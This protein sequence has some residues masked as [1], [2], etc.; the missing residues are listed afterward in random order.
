MLVLVGWRFWKREEKPLSVRAHVLWQELTGSKDFPEPWQLKATERAILAEEE[1]ARAEG[2]KPRKPTLEDVERELASEQAQADRVQQ[3]RDAEMWRYQVGYIE[4][5]QATLDALRKG[6]SGVPQAEVDDLVEL[7]REQAALW[8]SSSEF[9]EVAAATER[10]PYQVS[11]EH[12]ELADA[13]EADEP[14][15]P[16]PDDELT[17]PLF[18]FGKPDPNWL[19][20]H[21]WPGPGGS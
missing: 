18:F 12:R 21:G 8:K 17:R 20:R 15:W 10:D 6:E 16:W 13:L 4:R 11:A 9:A 5:V 2:R 19:K 7:L 14:R 1:A 3:E